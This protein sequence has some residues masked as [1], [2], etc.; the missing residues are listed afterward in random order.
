MTCS[1]S[2]G[3]PL[4]STHSL[5]F[6]NTPHLSLSF[7][8]LLKHLTAKDKPTPTLTRPRQHGKRSVLQPASDQPVRPS[9]MDI[10][11]FF[12]SIE[13]YS[14]YHLK[15]IM[16]CEQK[17]RFF[18]QLTF[19]KE[20]MEQLAESWTKIHTFTRTQRHSFTFISDEHECQNSHGTNA[21]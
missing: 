15:S 19:L 13:A 3:P 1:L 7:F 10:Q 4:C 16:R 20:E 5:I 17:S 8:F 14:V 6:Q 12:V 2:G 9:D 21:N 11:C 18:F